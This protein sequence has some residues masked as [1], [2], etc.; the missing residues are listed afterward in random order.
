MIINVYAMKDARLGWLQPT[1]E[2]N[3]EVA[4]RNFEHAVQTSG[5]IMTSHKT[6]FSLYKIGT[7]DTESGLINSCIPEFI[8]G[9]DSI[10]F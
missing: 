8:V 5:T 3:D 7:F 6:D 10:V 1:F 4:F 9:G 2:P